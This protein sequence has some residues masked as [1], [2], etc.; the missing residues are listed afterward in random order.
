MPDGDVENQHAAPL[1]FDDLGA[2]NGAV[3]QFASGDAVAAR[4]QPRGA[5]LLGV[6][7]DAVDDVERQHVADD[8]PALIRGGRRAVGAGLR[9]VAVEPLRRR[10]GH[11]HVAL[12][13]AQ[14]GIFTQEM[15][16]QPEHGFDLI[17]PLEDARLIEQRVRLPAGGALRC[18][19]Q[20][21]LL[22]EDALQLA[23][24]LGAFLAGQHAGEEGESIQL[25]AQN[26]VLELF[27]RH[28]DSLAAR[29]GRSQRCWRSGGQRPASRPSPASGGHPISQR[30]R[31]DE[32]AQGDQNPARVSEVHRSA[33]P[34][35]FIPRVYDDPQPA[36][37]D[38]TQTTRTPSPCSLPR[39]CGIG[40]PR[41]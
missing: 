22:L 29:Y 7:A 18:V 17:E 41:H 5:V 36:A 30:D 2:R 40:P 15:A 26:V 8:A 12:H 6:I 23:L 37:P 34:E 3:R 35:E 10:A 39:R 31:G 16:H 28:H 4:D 33:F 27:G 20:V 24:R 9:T 25:E 21:L 38:A 14:H 19:R 32:R 13:R 1:R 11:N